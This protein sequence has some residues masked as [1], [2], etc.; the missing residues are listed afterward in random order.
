MLHP[1]SV[2]LAHLADA[3]GIPGARHPVR[4][5]KEQKENAQQ[6][7]HEHEGLV[8]L[9]VDLQL[10]RERVTPQEPDKPRE[11][12]E[13]EG[14]DEADPARE[15]G[16]AAV[17]VHPLPGDARNEVEHKPARY[18]SVC[19][20][21]RVI[22]DQAL[23]AHVARCER[24]DDVQQEVAIDDRNKIVPEACR[25]N[26]ECKVE[27]DRV[28][29]VDDEAEAYQHPRD[30]E[31]R[32]GMDDREAN[33]APAGWDELHTRDAGLDEDGL[34]GRLAILAV[35]SRE[36]TARRCR[37]HWTIPAAV[38]GHAVDDHL[39]DE[40]LAVNARPL[41]AARLNLQSVVAAHQSLVCLWSLRQSSWLH[42]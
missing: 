27:G 19:D 5:A 41:A 20:T 31:V 2:L 34:Q 39:V 13:P 17:A 4:D 16:C 32:G 28:G 37:T 29:L 25:R 26:V 8:R 1:S 9:D 7:D 38:E 40:A 30:P 23:V 18:V 35:I 12:Q 11:A 33:P 3:N 24:H 6:A 15:R 22:H 21:R 36:G 42:R 10:L 14:P